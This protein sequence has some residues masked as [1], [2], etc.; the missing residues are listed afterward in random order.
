MHAIEFSSVLSSQYRDQLEDLLYFNR[1]QARAAPAIAHLV[2]K[3][4]QPWMQ[5]VDGHMRVGVGEIP[6]VQ[7][8]F[9]LAG[10]EGARRLVGAVIYMR[11]GENLVI[12]H[13]A[14]ARAFSY[15]GSERDALVV[16]RLVQA[17]RDVA[18]RLNGVHATILYYPAG[19]PQRLPVRPWSRAT[20]GVA[21]RSAQASR[22]ASWPATA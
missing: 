3:Y 7:T 1:L 22:D 21:T 18:Q 17:V 20:P 16:L 4:G 14:V 10:S 12:I 9:A 5:C 15:R 2:E 19:V 6:G 11:E 8:L 13:L